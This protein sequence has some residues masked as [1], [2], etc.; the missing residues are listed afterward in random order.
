MCEMDRRGGAEKKNY[1][2]GG[3]VFGHRTS[4]KGGQWQES[5]GKGYT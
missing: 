1:Q 2:F 3:G 5:Q 4:E